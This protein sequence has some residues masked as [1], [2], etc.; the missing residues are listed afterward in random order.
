MN[1][2]SIAGIIALLIIGAI[3]ASL[4]LREPQSQAVIRVAD[5]HALGW[6]PFQVALEQKFFEDEDLRIDV[7]VVQTGDESLKALASGS[8]DVALAG[9][10]PYSFVAFDSPSLRVIAQ[11]MYAHDN[12]ILARRASGISKPEDVRGKKIGYAK[13]TASDIGVKQFLRE[14]SIAEG[15]VKLVATKPLAMPVALASGQIDAYSAWEPHIY[16]GRKLLGDDAVLFDDAKSV[17][18]W[19]AAIISDERFVQE[20]TD[21]LVRF[22]R[23]WARAEDFMRE[24]PDETRVIMS[25]ST[26]IPEGVLESIMPKY[27]FSL[28]LPDDVYTTIEIDLAWANEQRAV[29]VKEL[30]RARDLVETRVWTAYEKSANSR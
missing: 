25:R 6:A 29:P 17:Y 23:A 1:K 27:E 7:I 4:V 30:P 19:H 18:T 13:T 9:I 24:H 12:Q 21:E 22:M 26:K 15:E 3:G 2:A 5:P 14:H 16:N 11:E 8:V 28:G 10:I 20:H